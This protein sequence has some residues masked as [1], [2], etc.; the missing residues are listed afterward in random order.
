M[1]DLGRGPIRTPCG[2]YNY[3]QP[4]ACSSYR[5]IF[6]L[7]RDTDK[8]A[9]SKQ[10]ERREGGGGKDAGKGSR[11]WRPQGDAGE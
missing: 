10:Y 4:Q 5:G 3:V 2:E 11:N 9:G 8:Q 7:E 1:D 6:H